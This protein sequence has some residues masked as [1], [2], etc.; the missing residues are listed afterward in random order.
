MPNDDIFFDS[1]RLEV[2][3]CWP[4]SGYARHGAI[5]DISP[6]V[7][8]MGFAADYGITGVITFADGASMSIGGTFPGQRHLVDQ[9]AYRR[10]EAGQHADA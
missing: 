4:T 2:G 8:D 7:G 10:A 5:V 1:D 6:Y 3:D 9:L